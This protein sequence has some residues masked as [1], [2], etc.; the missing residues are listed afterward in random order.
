MFACLYVCMYLFLCVREATRI[1]ETLLCFF[2]SV[3]AS[4][5]FLS[6]FFISTYINT[7][8]F[9]CLSVCLFVHVFLGHFETDWETLCHKLA[10]CSWECSKTIV[11]FK[12]SFL[13]ELLPF[14]IISLRF[15]CKFEERLQKNQ[16]RQ[17]SFF[18]CKDINRAQIIYIR[19][20]NYEFRHF[21]AMSKLCN[22]IE[23]LFL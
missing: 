11:F 5:Y 6:D 8:M 19:I 2:C 14:C 12:M 18:S 21:I 23:F 16:R 9:V 3:I 1:W 7:K 13:K 22:F 4:F 17:E 15:I 10:Y 20:H